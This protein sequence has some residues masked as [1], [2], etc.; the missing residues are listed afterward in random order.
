MTGWLNRILC[1][2]DLNADST[3]ALAVARDLAKKYQASVY[4]LYV[5]ATPPAPASEPA[6]DWQRALSSRFEKL[7]RDWFEGRVPYQ[8][9]IWSGDPAPA[10]L[11]AVDDLKADLVVMAIHG[12]K[13]IDRLIL[14][15][16]AE[17]VVRESPKPVLTVKPRFS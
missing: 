17:R 9:L 10:V 4:L 12:R 1:P 14:G 6:P 11:R 3:D 15:S 7:A 13:G 2:V 5:S 16:V 8:I